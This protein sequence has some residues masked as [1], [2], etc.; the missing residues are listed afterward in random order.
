M[1][2]KKTPFLPKLVITDIDGVW[3]DGGMYY[4]KKGNELKKFNTSDSA[5]VLFLKLLEIPVAI[6]TGENTEIVKRRADKLGIDHLYLGVKDKVSSAKSLCSVLDISLKDVAF[7]GDDINDILL[8]D[9]VGLSACP[10]SAPAYIKSRVDFVT[11]KIGGDGAFRE[12]IETLLTNNNMMDVALNKYL[13]NLETFN[14]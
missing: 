3:T 8:L 13:Y 11:D 6:M 12:F 10:S 9:S 7:I 1:S 4:D 2:T 5:G 14:Q